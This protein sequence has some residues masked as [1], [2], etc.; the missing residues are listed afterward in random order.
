MLCK[1]KDC[2]QEKY[3]ERMKSYDTKLN[4]M[5]DKFDSLSKKCFRV[6]KENTELKFKLDNQSH[7]NMLE[8]EIF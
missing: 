3:S 7:V 6:E 2:I 4:D 8:Q 1:T 5:L